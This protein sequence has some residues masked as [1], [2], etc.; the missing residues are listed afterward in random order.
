MVS[1]DPA[2]TKV[3]IFG[4]VIDPSYHQAKVTA[5]GLHQKNQK[6][7]H[8]PICKGMVE[9]EWKLFIEN[10]KQDCGG[11]MMSFNEKVLV[12]VNDEIIG[13]ANDFIIY[14]SKNFGFKDFRPVALFDAMARMA[15]EEN[16][17]ERKHDLMY[18]NIK[19]GDEMVGKLLIELFNDLAPKTCTN[20]KELC[21]GTKQE[22]EK[23]DPPLNLAYKGSIFHRV[24]KNGWIQ[25]GDI[26][27]GSGNNGWSVF[28]ETFEDENYS[29]LHTKRGIIG[30]ANKG[31]HT[32]ASQFYITFQPAPWMDCKYVAF[33]EVI[34]GMDILDKMEAIDTYNERPVSECTIADCGLVDVKKW[35]LL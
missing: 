29:V 6:T 15:Y 30:M 22:S 3:E 21:L 2:L 33:G 27:H 1:S 4:L 12:K 24:V 28:G 18:M 16:L 25:G 14:A 5:E 11:S 32:N 13:E 31:R 7:F 23:N 35:N 9:K 10:L 34:E 26:V 20:F 17:L 19:I 8:Y